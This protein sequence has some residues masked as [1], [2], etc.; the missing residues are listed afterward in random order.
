MPEMDGYQFLHALQDLKNE[1]PV[2]VITADK[3]EKTVHDVQSLGADFVLTK[4]VA[5]D[6]LLVILKEL[7]A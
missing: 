7:S 3:S 6:A 2:I 1:M 4:P 5:N